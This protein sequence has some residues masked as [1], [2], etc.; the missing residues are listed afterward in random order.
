MNLNLAMVQFQLDDESKPKE[1]NPK[2]NLQ[3]LSVL[4][5]M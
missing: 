1:S 4:Y 5:N 3:L 2:A